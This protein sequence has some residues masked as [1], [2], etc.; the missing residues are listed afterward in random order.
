VRKLIAAYKTIVTLM[1]LLLITCLTF[2]LFLTSCFSQAEPEIHLIPK[3]YRG[4]VIIIFDQKNG[5][6]EKYEDGSR[7]YKVPADGIL[8][9]QFI[10]QTKGSIR[11]GKLKYYYYDSNDRK[12]INYLQT[13]KGAVDDGMDYVFGKEVSSGSV[14]YLVGKLSEGD[15]YFSALRKKLEVIFPPTIQ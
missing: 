1:K 9:T 8:K 14:R 3:G 5:S 15:N 4:P 13:T 7:V 12:E 6:P 11:P 2:L 10:P